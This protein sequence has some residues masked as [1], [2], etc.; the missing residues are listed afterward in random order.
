VDASL[1]VEGNLKRDK[2]LH[3]SFVFSVYNLTGRDNPYSVYFTTEAKGIK[4]HQ[5]SVIAI[6][7]F[8]ATWVFKFGNF[9]AN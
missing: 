4:A 1:T 8:T 3:S 7:V 2:F 5:Y 9:D 6:P